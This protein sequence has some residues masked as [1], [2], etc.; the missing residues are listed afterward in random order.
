MVGDRYAHVFERRVLLEGVRY[1]H[2][3]VQDEADAVVVE[4]M[5]VR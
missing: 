4:A 2:G 3:H 1:V 5:A